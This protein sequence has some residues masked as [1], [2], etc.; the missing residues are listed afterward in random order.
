MEITKSAIR[1]LE[2]Q[3]PAMRKRIALALDEITQQEK[4]D[5]VYF[6]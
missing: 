6:T 3:E 2:R 1:F 4:L 5:N